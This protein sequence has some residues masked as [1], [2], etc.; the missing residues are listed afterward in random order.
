MLISECINALLKSQVVLININ[1]MSTNITR[2]MFINI[3]KDE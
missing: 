2:C 1:A 3:N